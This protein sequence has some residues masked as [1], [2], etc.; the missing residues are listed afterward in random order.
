MIYFFE[1]PCTKIAM[2]NAVAEGHFSSK[3]RSTFRGAR[4]LSNF[5]SG[6]QLMR[7]SGQQN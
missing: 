2:L 1:D 6:Q 3:Q 5:S 4:N 7:N